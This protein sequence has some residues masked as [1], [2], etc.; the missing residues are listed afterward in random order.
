MKKLV[1]IS[2][3]VTLLLISCSK[4]Y[5]I[6]SY[7]KQII[8][9]LYT[10]KDHLLPRRSH[11]IYS[12]SNNKY[13]TVS[14][15]DVYYKYVDPEHCFNDNAVNWDLYN[16]YLDSINNGTL[17]PDTITCEQTISIPYWF[18]EIKGHLFY[19]FQKDSLPEM[20]LYIPFKKRIPFR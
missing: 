19:C 11:F 16:Q 4:E 7:N 6:A 1:F 18:K 8:T 15:M 14:K 5:F 13:I 9:E 10:N 12:T 3:L 17:K 2:G 20:V